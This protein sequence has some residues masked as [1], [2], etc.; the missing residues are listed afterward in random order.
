MARPRS[1]NS[2]LTIHGLVRGIFSPPP[3]NFSINYAHIL[4]RFPDKV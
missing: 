1:Q 2:S 3:E 4:L